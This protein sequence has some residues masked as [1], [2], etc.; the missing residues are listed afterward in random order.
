MGTYEEGR[1]REG[2]QA[3]FCGTKDAWGSLH[4]ASQW[5]WEGNISHLN[6]KTDRECM[7]SSGAD[8]E[9]P[10]DPGGVLRFAAV[11]CRGLT[12][13]PT[14]ENADRSYGCPHPLPSSPPL[15]PTSF[16]KG[17]GSCLLQRSGQVPCFF[18]LTS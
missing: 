4:S 8:L 3:T 7:P 6:G 12:C 13:H 11:A 16:L 17:P 15:A 10:R 18:C 9:G 5:S 2:A 14:S 1:G